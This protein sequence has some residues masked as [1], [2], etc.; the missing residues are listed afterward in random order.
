MEWPT[1]AAKASK[2]FYRPELDALRFLAFG[3]VFL[4]HAPRLA[5]YPDMP[6]HYV[7]IAKYYDLLARAGAYGLCV[8]FLLSAYLISELLLREKEKTGCIHLK[9]FYMRRIL[10]IWP[11]YY[12]GVALGLLVSYLQPDLYGLSVSQSLYLL[13]FVGWLGGTMHGNPFGPLWSIS[14]EELF[15]LIWPGIARIS[16]KKSLFI[17]ALIVVPASLFAAAI[18]YDWYNP[19]GHFIFFASGTLLAIFFHRRSF[20]V[21]A[22][23]RLLLL[24]AGVLA[25]V[26][27]AS[28][29]FNPVSTQK[30]AIF[31]YTLIDIGCI[32]IFLAIFQLPAH[33]LPKWTLYLGQISYGLYVF[34]FFCITQTSRSLIGAGFD[35]QRWR[36]TALTMIIAFVFTVI[37]ASLSY[38]FFEKPFLRLKERFTFVASRSSEVAQVPAVK[39]AAQNSP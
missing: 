8:F 38:R 23:I 18:H 17:G 13:L 20:R 27:V 31:Q 14:V 24:F 6:L 32:A 26:V 9:A 35:L 15:Y 11:L 29:R 1:V 12:L 10:R 34:H 16:G 21:A 30:L 39:V 3:F 2:P 19:L 28:D 4:C 7:R 37:F 5:T 25:W 36:N 33:W 22:P